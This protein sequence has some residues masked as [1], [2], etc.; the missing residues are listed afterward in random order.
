MPALEATVTILFVFCDVMMFSAFRFFIFT[1]RITKYL[2]FW[3]KIPLWG[4]HLLDVGRHVRS[5]HGVMSCF[6]CS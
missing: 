5:S 6:V 3:R 4:L 2:R 1:N